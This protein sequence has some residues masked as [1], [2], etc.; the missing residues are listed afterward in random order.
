VPADTTIFGPAQVEALIDQD[1]TISAQFTLWDQSGSDVV[2]G[3]LIVVPV[4]DS[5]L[6]LQPVYLKSTGSSFPAF[7]RII[8]ASPQKVVWAP[9]LSEALNL[10]LAGGSGSS[11]S[12]SPS[13]GPPG[14]P[15]AGPSA[16]PSG[17]PAIS[18]PPSGGPLPTDVA[19]LVAY[20]NAHFD[21][22]QAA[23]RAGDFARYGNEM[24]LVRQALSQLS[25]LTGSTP[26]ASPSAAP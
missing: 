24:T 16:T 7:Q 11:P 8:V 10:L 15:S 21:A 19:G 25:V 3:N 18:P 2:R 13:P 12:P 5:L 22:A 4:R 23:L 14:G 6:Y 26:P 1:P 20:A 17:S 9:T